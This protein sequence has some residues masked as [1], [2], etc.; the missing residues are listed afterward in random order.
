M[1]SVSSH[2]IFFSEINSVC[3]VS[4]K[5]TYYC[6]K[7]SFLIWWSSIVSTFIFPVS[8]CILFIWIFSYPARCLSSVSQHYIRLL[9]FI[10]CVVIYFIV[11]PHFSLLCLCLSLFCCSFPNFLS[12]TLICFQSSFF[13]DKCI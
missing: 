13:P 6:S 9:L 12:W 1:F 3:K 4:T 10:F 2:F 8:F 7:H 11:S 5:L